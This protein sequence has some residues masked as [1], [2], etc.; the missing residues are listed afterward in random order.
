MITLFLHS[1]HSEWLK[2][3]R[4]LAAWLVVIGALFTPSIQTLIQI[5]RP[6]KTPARFAGTEFW[7]HYFNDAW[8]AMASLL[9]PM[10]I[11]LAVS[12]VAQLEY[13]NN[14]WK[15]LHAT[16]QP[17]PVIFFSK[18]TVLLTME[19]QLFLLFNIAIILSAAATALALPTVTFP[20]EPIP[21]LHF[22]RQ[23]SLYFLYALPIVSLQFLLSLLFRNFLVAVGAGLVLLV[24]NLLALSWEHVYVFP[25]SYPMLHMINR[26][27]DIN[28]AAWSGGWTI[29]LLTVAYVLYIKKADKG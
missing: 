15:Q 9:L 8:Q 1:L 3:K 14:T 6:E 16:P 19:L 28:L 21:A 25:Y 18:L 26:F 17:Y 29:L 24:T 23:S 12:L 5:I 27:P 13:K 20:Q 10:G 22:L 4:S 2:R 7:V 11:T